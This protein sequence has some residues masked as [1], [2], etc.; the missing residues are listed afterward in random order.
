MLYKK[1]Y[2][3]IIHASVQQSRNRLGANSRRKKR[4][5]EDSDQNGIG[6]YSSKGNLL[7]Q[8]LM[9]LKFL[10]K[11]SRVFIFLAHQ[12]AH[13]EWG[14]LMHL[15]WRSCNECITKIRVV[16]R[17]WYLWDSMT[18]AA[19]CISLYESCNPLHWKPKSLSFKNNS[20]RT[21]LTAAGPVGKNSSAHIASSSNW[22][23]LKA[24][25]L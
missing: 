9:G 7:L 25:R 8:Y 23:Y 12:K 16:D 21:H 3:T 17:N 19:T 6:L 22:M 15:F 20:V 24:L 1:V 4:G 13:Q 5:R 14:K 2:I 10:T 18:F 11:Q